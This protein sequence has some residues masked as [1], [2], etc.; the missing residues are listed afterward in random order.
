[1]KRA[2]LSFSNI[3][4]ITACLVVVVSI[5][6]LNVINTRNI[7]TLKNS[8]DTLSIENKNIS[9]LRTTSDELL[10]AELNF[11]R[12][13]QTGDTSLSLVAANLMDKAIGHL[14]LLKVESDSGR[15]AQITMQLNKDNSLSFLIAEFESISHQLNQ[16][17]VDLNNKLQVD[18]VQNKLA[19]YNLQLKDVLIKEDAFR[20]NL[21]A[22]IF[23]NAVTGTDVIQKFFWVSLLIILFIVGVLVYNIYKMVNYE[24]E[25]LEARERAVKLAQVKSRFLSNMSHEIRSPLTA[26]MGFTEIIDKSETDLDKKN[27]LHAI[28]TSS[29]HLLSTVNDVLDFS[30]LDAGKLK[31]DK[32]PFYISAAIQEVAFALST[33]SAAKKGVSVDTEIDLDKNL[34]LKGDL[35]RLKQILYNLLSNAVKF[36][37]K[38]GVVIKASIAG[39]SAN[40]VMIK[41]SVADSGIGIPNDQIKTVFEEFTQVTNNSTSKDTRRAIKGT[42][43]G[44]SICK[45][46]VE[47]Q[48]G[49]I[50]VE[51][52]LNHGSVF[53]FAIPYEVANDKVENEKEQ[54]VMNN[55]STSLKGKRVL[56]IED[57]DVNI[58]L[59]TMLLK[60]V[61]IIYDIAKDGE[62]GLQFFKDNQYDII[63]TDINVPKL[64]GDEIAVIVR[65]DTN[66][67]KRTIPIVGLTA[68][69]VQDDLDDYINSGIN[70]VLVKPFKQDD[71]YAIIEKYVS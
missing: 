52:K 42:G 27:F 71:L 39:T 8:I 44:L 65:Q 14:K 19:T 28:K 69:I 20:E 11:T 70:E 55:V 41:I 16:S 23:K 3:I 7:I 32:Q 50:G 25:I 5:L 45:M 17:L 62:V 10:D 37:E 48:G 60:K 15:A 40:Q 35:F 29:E 49:T 30:K 53:T 68:T 1:M 38:G 4:L 57:N 58:M 22:T 33:T 6:F 59:L 34:A 47:L 18:S 13:T 63:L 12:Y 51:S 31:L 61:G 24:N 64:T 21:N 46:L 26:I 56:V 43:L 54:S 67:T 36:T 66:E 9:I 2:K